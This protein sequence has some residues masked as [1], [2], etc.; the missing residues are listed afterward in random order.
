LFLTQGGTQSCLQ[1]RRP[2]DSDSSSDDEEQPQ[3]GEEG[4]H[5]KHSAV[6]IRSEGSATSGEAS[7]TETASAPVVV[8]GANSKAQDDSDDIS[9]MLRF[10][11][12]RYRDRLLTLLLQDVT[13]TVRRLKEVDDAEEAIAKEKERK[14]KLYARAA[15]RPLHHQESVSAAAA[16]E[17]IREAEQSSRRL[18]ARM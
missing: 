11:E 18:M 8:T 15:T 4:S 9:D 17:K 3:V 6:V 13:D 7:A 12:T 1:H 10:L 14:R 5:T 2:A 16:R